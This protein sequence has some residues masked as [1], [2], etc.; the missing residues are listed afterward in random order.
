MINLA[1]GCKRSSLYGGLA[2][3]ILAA[4]VIMVGW[5]WLGWGYIA[6]NR[7]LL[8]SVPVP[9]GAERIH[10]RSGGGYGSD[11]M[12]L[13]PPEG[14][15]TLARF[16]VSGYTRQ[17]IVDFY[18]AQMSPDWQHCLRLYPD[19]GEDPGDRLVELLGVHFV[20]GNSIVSIDTAS[21]SARG[22]SRFDIYVDHDSDR[23]A[24]D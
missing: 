4:L 16:R 2:L 1:A 21:L 10:V 17:E 13:T 7:W 23:N 22:S 12:V 15:G 9:T 14:W 6:Q 11:D 5:V 3:A 18:I 19:Y 24:C 8:K 20:R